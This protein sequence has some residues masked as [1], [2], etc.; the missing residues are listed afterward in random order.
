MNDQACEKSVN[1]R[2]QLSLSTML[3]LVTLFAV[4]A[5]FVK[6]RHDR[7]EL[8]RLLATLRPMTR[9]LSVDNPTQIAV[10]RRVPTLSNELIFDAYIPKPLV[11][12]QVHRLCLVLEE[13]V[14]SG[15]FDVLFPQPTGSFDL[16]PGI[17]SIEL[18]STEADKNDV[19]SEH[20]FV[21]LVDGETVIKAKRP[22]VWQASNGWTSYGTIS[23]SQA[24]DA[25]EAVQLLRRRNNE[26]NK[27]FSLSAPA[28]KPTNGVLLW[29]DSGD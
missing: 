13:I 20:R 23:Q 26:P 29:I 18:R 24:F 9:E 2:W 14:D 7:N 27:N 15:P 5:G 16:Q 21:V 10:V 25:K 4:G 12:T 11:P 1:R 22:A 6:A 17:H 3:L 8:Q 28:K 19:N